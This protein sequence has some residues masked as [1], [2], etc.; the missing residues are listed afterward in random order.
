MLISLS[1]IYMTLILGS[2]EKRD[3]RKAYNDNASWPRVSTNRQNS[4]FSPFQEHEFG[5]VLAFLQ[6]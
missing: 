5:P 1:F 6:R 3:Y 2:F 4:F